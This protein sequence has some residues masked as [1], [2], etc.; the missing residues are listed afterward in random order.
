MKWHVFL[1]ICENN[2]DI[3]FFS[4]CFQPFFNTDTANYV[5]WTRRVLTFSSRKKRLVYNLKYL[6]V[7]SLALL[8]SLRADRNSLPFDEIFVILFSLQMNVLKLD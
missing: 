8:N 4:E 5:T 6:S 1:T 2:N 3:L 7:T